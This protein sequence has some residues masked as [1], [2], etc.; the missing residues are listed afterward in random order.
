M[1]L[2]W[3]LE[4]KSWLPPRV[5]CSHMLSCVGR[6]FWSEDQMN[7]EAGSALHLSLVYPLP[8]PFLLLATS[9]ISHYSSLRS[10]L[11]LH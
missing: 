11:A 10:I 3:N 5:C 2:D 6:P 9:Q 8:L 4:P 1:L 7:L